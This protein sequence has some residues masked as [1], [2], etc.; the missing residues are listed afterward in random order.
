MPLYITFCGHREVLNP[1]R[2][3]K[4]LLEI[5]EDFYDPDGLEIADPD[6]LE[7]VYYCGGY[8]EFDG[9]ASRAIDEMRRRYPDVTIKKIFV[10]PYITESAQEKIKYIKD[11]YDEILYPPLENVPPKYAIAKRNEWMI[12]HSEYLIAYVTHSWGGAAKTLEYARKKR[13]AVYYIKD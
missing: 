6:I 10:T 4:Q 3:Y 11:Y 13:L 2:V 1:K 7:I 5:L 9:L 8:G 12:K